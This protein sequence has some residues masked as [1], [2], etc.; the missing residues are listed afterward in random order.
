[1][2]IISVDHRTAPLAVRERFALTSERRLGLMRELHKNGICSVLISTCNRFEVCTDYGGDIRPYICAAAGCTLRYL[3]KYAVIKT[4][5]DAAEHLFATAAG[6]NSMVLGEDQILGQIKRAFELSRS[7]G[8]TNS[9]LNTL[10]RLAVTSAKR[11]KTETLLSSTPVSA[12]GIALKAARS[13][14][15]GTVNTALIIGAGGKTGSVIA[16]DLAGLCREIITI[17]GSAPRGAY[18][19]GAELIDYAARYDYIDDADLI[20]SATTA[21]HKTIEERKI[22]F[23]TR[24]KRVFLDMAVPSDMDVSPSPENIVINID[25]I[26]TAAE[27]N[28]RTR[29]AEA[30]RALPIIDRCI[31][32]FYDWLE[33]KKRYEHKNR[34]ALKRAGAS[35]GTPCNA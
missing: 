12:A 2:Q 10:F 25:M 30:L 24:K 35:S 34:N 18:P 20:V 15:G 9:Y 29:A 28:N 22:T 16:K 1:M 33:R 31:D 19:P 32:E 11:V 23:K 13:E 8:F 5:R 3:T 7:M 26:K 21:P 6:L 27:E 17:R 4:G 14:L